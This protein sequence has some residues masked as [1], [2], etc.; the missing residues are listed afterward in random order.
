MWE[1]IKLEPSKFALNLAVILIITLW[2][3][4]TAGL[5]ISSLRDA[6]LIAAS[7]W[8]TALSTADRSAQGRTKPTTEQVEQD[9]KF[10]IGGNLFEGVEGGGVIKAFGTRVAKPNEFAAGTTATCSDFSSRA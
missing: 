7:G 3:L 10:V 6:N 2:T 5:L 4:P 9:G 8:W 1:R